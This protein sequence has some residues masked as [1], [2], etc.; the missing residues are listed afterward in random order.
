MLRLNIDLN[1]DKYD[2][3]G[4]FSK[5]NTQTDLFNLVMKL[6]LPMEACVLNTMINN[7]PSPILGQ[8][9]RINRLYSGPLD[10][11]AADFIRSCDSSDQAPMTFYVSKMIPLAKKRGQFIAFGRVFSGT[12]KTGQK[13][14]I[15]AENGGKQYDSFVKPVKK[16]V[17]MMGSYCEQ[18]DQCQAGMCNTL[19]FFVIVIITWVSAFR[20]MAYLGQIS[21]KVRHL[22][23][24]YGLK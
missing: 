8:S 24:L 2:I 12:I 19:I 7:I 13:V 18:I 15:M 3:N 4:N 10:S 9:N 17:L 14:E 11:K 5:F 22:P 6:W 21:T 20:K 23:L 16:I 1:N